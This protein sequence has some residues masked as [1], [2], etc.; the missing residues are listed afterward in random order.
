MSYPAHN[1]ITKATL[2]SFMDWFSRI[3]VE[4][5]GSAWTTDGEQVY[6]PRKVI[7]VPIQWATRDKWFEIYNSS[8]ARKSMDPAIREKNPVEVAWI[9]PRICVYMNGIMYDSM[10]KLTKTQQLR[11]DFPGD[12]LYDRTKQYT[13]SPYNLDV[14]VAVVS[15][16]LDDNLQIMEQIIPYFAP[17]MNIN[18]NLVPGS[19][20]SSIPI[21]LNGIITDIPM[22]LGENDERF[23]TFTYNFSIKTSFYPRKHIQTHLI[24][25]VGTYSA[26][27]NVISVPSSAGIIPGMPV[28]GE[29]IGPNT[30]VL[31][32]DASGNVLI[33]THT[34]ASGSNVIVNFGTNRAIT[35][36]QTKLHMGKDYVQIDQTWL[37][38]LNA[39]EEK[40]SEF[41]ANASIPN[42]FLG[43]N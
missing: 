31:S 36:V 1:F 6:V 27:S 20:S 17:E 40:F 3:E 43:T 41:E 9:L 13:P 11:P 18:V 33:S 30:F 21:V 29:G 23:V 37:E 22:D 14:D 32:F 15:K 16:T 28:F 24:P 19:V 39:I 25:F 35:H 10:R 26:V 2:V 4:R 12:T 38:Q 7:Q 42:P 8:S 5:L 34:S